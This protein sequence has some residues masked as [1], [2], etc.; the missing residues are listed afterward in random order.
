MAQRRVLKYMG[1]ADV[2]T[3]EKGEDLGGQMAEPLGT[4]LVF[5]EAN[6]FVIDLNDEKYAGISD[7]FVDTLLAHEPERFKDVSNLKVIPPNGFQ[8][9]FRG[10]KQGTRNDAVADDGDDEPDAGKSNAQA[11]KAQGAVKKASS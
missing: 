7:E 3:L 9:T 11:T 8:T 10:V 6:R 2:V 4:E 1:M 5:S